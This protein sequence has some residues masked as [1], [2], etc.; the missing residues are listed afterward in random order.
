MQPKFPNDPRLLSPLAQVL[1]L[2]GKDSEALKVYASLLETNPDLHWVED[3]QANILTRLKRY[4]EARALRA[5]L[6]ARV[7]QDRQRYA[8]LARIYALQGRPDEYLTWLKTRVEQ[9]PGQSALLQAMVDEYARQKRT[10]EG[11]ALL[12]AVMSRHQNDRQILNAYAELLAGNGRG[13]DA[14]DVLGRL[15]ALSPK[16]LDAQA[17]YADSLIA[18][19]RN[20]EAMRVFQ[21]QVARTDISEA[22]RAQMRQL[23]AQRLDQQGK[24]ADAI[25]QYREIVKAQP[26]NYEAISALLRLLRTAG[27]RDDLIAVCLDLLKQPGY[28][29]ALR[30]QLLDATGEAYEQQNNRAAARLQ[31]RQALQ[32]NTKDRTAMEG[33][34]RIGEN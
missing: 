31:F 11:W 4:D 9:T 30:A 27:Q 25:A 33:L 2:T 5:R 7:P 20:V 1:E 8:D 22:E 29:P 26:R 14:T 12:H 24:A 21:Q 32:I 15:A 10:D 28:P 19:G 16:D 17:E 18:S 34:R 13:P 6:I 3:R 23:W